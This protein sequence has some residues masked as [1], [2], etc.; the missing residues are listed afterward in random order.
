MPVI[1]TTITYD[2]KMKILR[3]EKF[4]LTNKNTDRN[5]RAQFNKCSFKTTNM[6]KL[7]DHKAACHKCFKCDH[8]EFRFQ[9][10]SMLHQHKNE[11]HPRETHMKCNECDYKSTKEQ[12]TGEHKRN[13]Q[14]QLT[15][16]F[17]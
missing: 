13:V 7:G 1:K 11:A 8:C 3:L 6:I 5:R 2:L 17:P 16:K 9:H 4:Q 12:N 10:E 14:G 15:Q